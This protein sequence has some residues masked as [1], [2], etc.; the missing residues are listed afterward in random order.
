LRVQGIDITRRNE[1][2]DSLLHLAAALGKGSL[3]ASLVAAG[4][5]PNDAGYQERRPIHAAAWFGGAAAV[6]VLCA[7]GADHEERDS[8]GNTALHWAAHRGHGAPEDGQSDTGTDVVAA[9]FAASDKTGACRMN[10]VCRTNRAKRTVFHAAAAGGHI[11]VVR[12]LLPYAG[13]AQ[14]RDEKGRTAA[15][16]AS[17][18]GHDDVAALI[19]GWTNPQPRVKAWVDG[20]MDAQRR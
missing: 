12:Q 3:I 9:L 5:D 14:Q 6:C 15:D 2:G 1:H 4:L 16:I 13:G 20:V 18:F 10:Y 8:F 11:N 19:E 17:E 7:C